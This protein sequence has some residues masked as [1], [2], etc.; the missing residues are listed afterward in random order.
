VERGRLKDTKL[1]LQAPSNP[2]AEE[3][4]E[5]AMKL[6]GVIL[7]PSIHTHPS[8]STH[9]KLR[10]TTTGAWLS[11]SDALTAIHHILQERSKSGLGVSGQPTLHFSERDE[12]PRYV[13]VLNIPWLEDCH[14]IEEHG[15][16]RLEAL[17][18][19]CLHACQ[20]LQTNGLLEP[21]HFPTVY[22]FV[23]VP[24]TTEPQ[25]PK[26]AKS[27]VRTHPRRTPLFWSLSTETLG[28]LRYPTVVFI[29]GSVGEFG[30]LAILTRH[31]LPT[32]SDFSLFISGNPVNARLRKCQL[33]P[34]SPHEL[35][36]LRRTTLRIMRFVGNK[37]FV[38]DLNQLPYLLLPLEPDSTLPSSLREPW[39]AHEGYPRLGNPC[40][41][42]VET[43][44]AAFAFLPIAT[45]N[46]KE[47]I[48][49][50]DNAVIQDRKIEY[51]KHYFVD[52]IREDLTPQHKP[53][54][55]EV[56]V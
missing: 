13:C 52:R 51:T 50:L 38:C 30:L 32:I 35:E 54:E 17:V 26:K 2:A 25:P 56:K 42:G 18:S 27:G 34:L 9:Q 33:G 39:R 19:G 7:P 40:V 43:N 21:A 48:K 55:G 15:H 22:P 46:T 3:W 45:D 37:P 4:I 10:D 44:M 49:D 20:L 5:N 41:S 6:D 1:S 31:P 47:L 24:R 23:P 12:T 8:T 14:N 29:D 28:G 16:S 36:N 53:Q 11:P